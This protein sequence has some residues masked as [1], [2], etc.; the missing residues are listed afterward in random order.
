MSNYTNTILQ[1]MELPGFIPIV[2]IYMKFNQKL[3]GR[4]SEMIYGNNNLHFVTIT[5]E[6]MD[7]QKS[8]IFDFCREIS[9]TSFIHNTGKCT[10]VFLSKK[11][12]VLF[13]LTF[14]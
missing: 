5:K 10:F 1:L 7:E 14:S 8:K 13:K 11:D 6:H 2:D 4:L 12:A 3:T 9:F